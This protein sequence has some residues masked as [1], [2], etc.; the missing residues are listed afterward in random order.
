MGNIGPDLYPVFEAALT[1]RAGLEGTWDGPEN[2]STMFRRA[3]GLMDIMPQ[4]EEEKEAMRDAVL[5]REGLLISVFDVLRRVPRRVLMVMKLND[6]TRSLDHALMTTHS[7]I[8]IFLIA[9]KYCTYAVWQDD[10]K[11]L[12]G[13][14]RDTGLFSFSLLGEYFRCWWKFEKMYT[15]MMLLEGL[16][17]WQAWVVKTRAWVRGLFTTGFDGAHK[18][19]AGLV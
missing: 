3:T 6:L 14:M 5:S 8:R 10:R 16:M 7:N 19:A 13:A 2:D 4:T 15:R 9:A 17:D 11:R 18:A 12:I 1:G